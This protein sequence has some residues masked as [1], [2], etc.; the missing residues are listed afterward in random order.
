MLVIVAIFAASR[1]CDCCGLLG[2]R[3]PLIIV[4]AIVVPFG[5]SLGLWCSKAAKIAQGI[6]AEE[7][8][9]R[10]AFTSLMH[11]I[12]ESIKHVMS[13]VPCAEHDHT[14]IEKTKL[15]CIEFGLAGIVT[16]TCRGE[17]KTF[18]GWKSLR[19]AVKLQLLRHHECCDLGDPGD[20]GDPDPDLQAEADEEEG[21]EDASFMSL[22]SL[23]ES[24]P[25]LPAKA[26]QFTEDHPTSSIKP[27]MM[28][29]IH[30]G[31]SKMASLAGKRLMN[32]LLDDLGKLKSVPE[33]CEHL[34]KVVA[35][36]LFNVIGPT[37][38]KFGSLAYTCLFAPGAAE[39]ASAHP[40]LAAVIKVW[41]TAEALEGFLK[42]R[43]RWALWA[44][45]DFISNAM[46]MQE[47]AHTF[48]E[49]FAVLKAG[50]EFAGFCFNDV[51]ANDVQFET[52][53]IWVERWVLILEWFRTQS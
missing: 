39:D 9:T 3:L 37:L 10:T 21:G 52:Q 43:A 17:E 48:S 19:R 38:L 11:D 31:F 40:K 14:F 27:S 35:E 44:L 26:M 24:D 53:N 25:R 49:L 2:D 23:L 20:P 33:Q 4:C 42:L 15:L 29:R 8:M 36:D 22:S 12:K 46:E 34:M 16:L 47:G 1:A 41:P 28:K 5:R 51:V 50:V 32:G 7:S 18:K 30:P 45:G 13:Y 6:E